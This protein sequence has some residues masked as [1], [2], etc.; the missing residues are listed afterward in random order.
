MQ[1]ETKVSPYQPG[2]GRIMITNYGPHPAS[3]WAQVTA[4]HIVPINPGMVGE[5]QNAEKKLQVAVAEALISHHAN[6]QMTE[7]SNIAASPEHIMLDLNPE[8][9]LDDAAAAVVACA[10]GTA[11][12]AHFADPAVQAL[13]RQEIGVHFATSQHIERSWHVDRNP[14]HPHAAAWKAKHHGLGA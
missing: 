2:A 13:V 10:K 4:E 5:K 3:A 14:S 11:W 1:Q 7:Q 8:P 6:V 12:E 9:H